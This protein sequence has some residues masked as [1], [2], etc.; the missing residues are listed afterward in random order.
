M[1]AGVISSSDPTCL[2]TIATV[3]WNAM[4]WL[5]VCMESVRAQL[6]PS[7]D[8]EH[9]VVDGASTDGTL[10]YLHSLPHI[11]LVSERDRGISDAMNKAIRLA[12]GKWIL[13]LNADDELA[14]GA[15]EWM[16]EMAS[17]H[18]DVGWIQG[19]VVW[20]DPDGTEVGHQIADARKIKALRWSTKFNQQA[21]LMHRDLYSRFGV[22]DTAFRYVM[23]YDFWLRVYRDVPPLCFDFVVTRY[24]MHWDSTSRGNVW[25]AESEKH[26]AR[27]K[28]RTQLPWMTPIE[29]IALVAA[30]YWKSPTIAHYLSMGA[31]RRGDTTDALKWSLRNLRAKPFQS[32]EHLLTV[33]RALEWK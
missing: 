4:P 26:R 8:V 24:R 30:T 33:L 7:L 13:F 20:I 16:C 14:P 21:A 17:R 32:P 27:M 29:S 11:R 10:E 18:P 6:S 15:L 23:D 28:N 31:A 12:R 25:K 2:V 1:S 19:S 5:P 22:Y 3:C 9:L